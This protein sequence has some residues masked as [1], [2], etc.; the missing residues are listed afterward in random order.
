MSRQYLLALLSGGLL[1]LGFPPASLSWMAFLGL[2]PLLYALKNAP[3]IKHSTCIGFLFGFV[4][5]GG[6]HAFLW[7]LSQF[8]P[9]WGIFI[10][11][12]L[13]TIYLASF[14][15]LFGTIAY[16]FR[17]QSGAIYT[18]GISCSLV[19]TEALRQSG[20]IGSPGG[21]LGYSQINTLIAPLASWTGILGVSFF[22][23]LCTTQLS[24]Y[25]GKYTKKEPTN[26]HTLCATPRRG[27]PSQEMVFNR[28]PCDILFWKNIR[29]RFHCG[30]GIETKGFTVGILL[31]CF[32]LAYSTPKHKEIGQLLAASI[33]GNHTQNHKITTHNTDSVQS[34][35]LRK[36]KEAID[37]GATL[38]VWPETITSR[39]N[40]HNPIFMNQLQ[41]LLP[42]QTVVFWGTPTWKNNQFYNSIVMTS[43][44]TPIYSYYDKHHLVPFGEYW[45]LKSWFNN[46]GIA[47]LIP[48]A[49][50]SPGPNTGPLFPNNFSAAICLESVYGKH[51]RK[52]VKS[53]SLGFII[54]GNHAWYGKSSAAEKHVD[55]LRFR[56][57]EYRRSVVFATNA[58]LSALIGPNG[59]VLTIGKTQED[60]TLIAKIPLHKEMTFYTTYGE[61]FSWFCGIIVLVC[62]LVTRQKH[63]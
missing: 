26:N 49:E 10:I 3:T 52:Q 48:G 37:L 25:L 47:N 51:F 53:G 13:Y 17:Q 18:L 44:E 43:R 27:A 54:T 55:I 50:Y 8:G 30:M 11:W 62:L 24:L 16:L 59:K 1:L 61:W 60:A 19:L 63:L 40:T 29:A 33:Q 7:E 22:V 15:A 20:P 41:Q 12:L 34:F 35:Y 9:L 31:L 32:L 28:T 4:F 23:I 56:A 14:Y 42:T 5:M 38:I 39:L 21:L 2:L 45:P 57:L 58:G 6:F 36:T 46:L